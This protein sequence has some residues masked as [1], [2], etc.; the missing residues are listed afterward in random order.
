VIKNYGL[1]WKRER[2]IWKVNGVDWGEAKPAR[3]LL[4]GRKG[5]GPLI[6]FC[7]RA[8]VYILHEGF[9]VIYV[10]QTGAGQQRLFKRLSDHTADH[11]AER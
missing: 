1:F 11:L 6:N 5:S 9:R 10:G 2:V 7:Y 8:G 3:G 4:L